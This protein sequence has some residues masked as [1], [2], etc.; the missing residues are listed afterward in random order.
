[1]GVSHVTFFRYVEATT[2]GGRTRHHGD[3]GSK[4]PREHTMQAIATLRCFLDKSIEHMPHRLM[5]LPTVEVVLTKTLLSSFKW[6]D[7]LLA[8]NSINSCLILK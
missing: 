3:F 6:K 7:T 8:L 4:K 2:S 5:T 1:M